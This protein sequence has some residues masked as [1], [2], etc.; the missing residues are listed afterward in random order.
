MTHLNT[1]RIHLRKAKVLGVD[2][3]TLKDIM[4]LGVLKHLFGAL[5]AL[6]SLKNSQNTHFYPL[7]PNCSAPWWPNPNTVW[8]FRVAWPKLPSLR[9]PS[10]SSN[11]KGNLEW[12]LR[13]CVTLPAPSPIIYPKKEDQ[14]CLLVEKVAMWYEPNF[15]W[16]FCIISKTQGST[17]SLDAPIGWSHTP[18]VGK[19]LWDMPKRW[20]KVLGMGPCTV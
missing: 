4:L 13:A 8:L 6:R 2:P 11:V 19:S 7:A 5:R 14:L 20:A 1:A 9:V 16:H 18:A 10:K 15:W 17:H 12:N 3:C